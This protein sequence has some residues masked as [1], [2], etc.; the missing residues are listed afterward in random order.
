MRDLDTQKE[1]FWAKKLPT[2]DKTGSGLRFLFS[3]LPTLPESKYTLAL[4][5]ERLLRNRLT[6]AHKT[7]HPSRQ[8]NLSVMKGLHGAYRN[9]R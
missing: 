1:E 3:Q 8:L 2:L 9:L 7:S 4:V 5:F 6:N